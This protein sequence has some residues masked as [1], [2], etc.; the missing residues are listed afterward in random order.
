MKQLSLIFTILLAAIAASWSIFTH[1]DKLE[2]KL[3]TNINA[4]YSEQCQL[5]TD[6]RVIETIINTKTKNLTK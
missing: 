1:F 4:L 5:K 2:T 6:I 3:E